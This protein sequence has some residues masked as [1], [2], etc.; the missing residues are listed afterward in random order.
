MTSQ[1]MILTRRNGIFVSDRQQTMADGKTY[2][3]IQKIFGI[4]QIHSSA[5]MIN[6]KADFENVPMETLIAEFKFKTDFRQIGTIEEISHRFINFLSKHTENSSTDG[7]LKEAL[8]PFKETLVSQIHEREFDEVI[9]EKQRRSVCPFIRN[10]SN[11]DSEFDDV[12]PDDKDKNQ[13]C[14]ILW[15][16]FSFELQGEST[17]IV[18]AGFNLRSHYPSFFEIEI[19]YN[20][21]GKIVYEV[22]DSDIDSKEPIIKVFAIN[23]EAYTFITGVN[24]DFID[25]IL[26]YISDANESILKNFRWDLEKENIE[27]VD[28]IIEFLKNEQDKEYLMIERYILDFRLDALEETTYSIKNLPEWLLCL[29]ADLLIRL[30]AVKQK[31]SSEIESVSVDTDILVMLKTDGFKWINNNEEYFKY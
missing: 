4:S 3:G 11:Y 24:D 28:K 1:A 5:I 29:F 2:G 16:I 14:Q 25:Y 27:N 8:I 20:D 19:Y 22:V 6:G 15:E 7:F 30:T 21:N 23:E 12:I 18:F 9:A 26:K 31:T 13:Y 10:Y 17:G